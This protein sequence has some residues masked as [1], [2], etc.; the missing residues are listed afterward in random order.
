MR[1]HYA[2][3]GAVRLGALNVAAGEWLVRFGRAPVPGEADA[4]GVS[5]LSRAGDPAEAAANLFAVLAELDARRVERIAV[6]PIPD[7]GLGEA[8]NDRLRRAAAPRDVPAEM[9]AESTRHG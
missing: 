2:P 6:M 5:E 9:L 4:S 8:V 7:D 1:S 3:H